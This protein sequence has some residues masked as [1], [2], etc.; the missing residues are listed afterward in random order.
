[1]SPG[2]LQGSPYNQPTLFIGQHVVRLAEVDSTNTFAMSLLRGADI[3]EGTVVAARNQTSGRGQRGNSWFSEPGKN[4]TCSIVLRPTFLEAPCQ[5]DLTRAVALGIT[6]LLLTLLPA[7]PVHIKWPNDIIAGNK[8]ICGVLIENALN[9]LQLST[10]VIGIGLN[11][12]QADFGSDAPRAVSLFH[13]TGHE[14]DPEET[15]K[16]LF[17]AIEARY[18][19]L[20]GNKTELLRNEYEA[21]LYRKGVPARYTD[22]KTIFDATLEQVTPEGLLVLRDTAGNERKFGFKEVGMLG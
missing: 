14:L 21:R 9:G 16:H 7:T 15:M 4:I 6:D 13:L 10:S 17:A 11:L 12:N 5:F 3:A 19:Q 8:K 2:S 20:R 22:F 1:M 18:L